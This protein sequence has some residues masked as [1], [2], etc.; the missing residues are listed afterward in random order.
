[1]SKDFEVRPLPLKIGVGFTSSEPIAINVEGYRY[2]QVGRHHNYFFTPQNPW[3]PAFPK[4]W[5]SD[6]PVIDGFSPNLNKELHVGHLR[7]LAIAA[8]LKRILPTARFVAMLGASLGVKKAAL[9]GWDW[10]TRWTNYRPHIYYD[11]ALPGDIVECR[12]SA[13]GDPE[14]K[15]PCP[16]VWDGPNGPVIVKRSDGTP[17]YAWHDLCFA[18]WVG[19]THYIT[20]HEQKEH[21]KS[22]GFEA[23]HLP[24]GLV[25]GSDGKKLKSRTGDAVS[26]SDALAMVQ[27][28][29]DETPCRKELAWNVIAWNMLQASRETNIKFEAEKWTNADSP[30]M[31]ISYTFARVFSALSAGGI[32]VGN[33]VEPETDLDLRLIGLSSYYN[34]YHQRAAKSFD[35]A[36]IANYSL[37]LAKLITSAYSKERIN[38]GRPPFQ[39]AIGKATDTLAECMYDLTMYDLKTV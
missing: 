2:E 33:F 38:G 29:L 32:L 26:A 5:N 4:A 31:Y 37:E 22:L 8:S 18:A 30:G 35:P 19:P 23:K 3:W 11:V 7:N 13:F 25:L 10:W 28:C 27:D 34:Y 24:M 21:F 36:P 9:D 12:R 16:M 6:T 17:L 39:Y 20:G 14:G 1:M 15:E